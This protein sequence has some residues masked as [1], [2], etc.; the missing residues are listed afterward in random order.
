MSFVDPRDDHEA[1]RVLVEAMDD[2]RPHRVLSPTQQI[3]QNVNQ[4]WSAMP[5]GRMDNQAGRLLD[6]RK[7]FVCVDDARRRAHARS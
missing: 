1:G 6:D 5:T 2:A 7:P 3:A 4:G